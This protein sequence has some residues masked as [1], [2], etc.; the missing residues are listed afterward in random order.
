MPYL[1]RLVALES[2]SSTGSAALALAVI[3]IVWTC[4]LVVAGGPWPGA[5]ASRRVVVCR[6]GDGWQSLREMV[7]TRFLCASCV[8]RIMLRGFHVK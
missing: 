7:K 2:T 4:V 3:S 5:S 6:R 8:I 1:F